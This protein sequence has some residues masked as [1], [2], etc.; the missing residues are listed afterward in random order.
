MFRKPSKTFKA[1]QRKF[2]RKVAKVEKKGDELFNSA[3]TEMA[4]M[5]G[6]LK[7]VVNRLSFVKRAGIAF[8]ILIGRW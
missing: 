2:D 4:E 1:A 3:Y 7:A 8:S 5:E 6:R